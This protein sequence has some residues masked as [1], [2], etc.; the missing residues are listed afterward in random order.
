MVAV[1][2]NPTLY[3]ASFEALNARIAGEPTWLGERRRAAM[4]RFSEAGFPTPHDEDW[5]YTNLAGISSG[6]F[7][8]AESAS[9]TVA[10]GDIRSVGFEAVDAHRVVFVNGKL[11]PELSRLDDRG[12]G[13]GSLIDKRDDPVVAAHLSRQADAL[14]NSLAALNTAFFEDGI[15]VHV[16]E[17]VVEKKPVHLVWVTTG[18]QAE[19][20]THPRTLIVAGRDSQATVIETFV[21]IGEDYWTNA[22]TEV[23][24]AENAHIEHYKLQQEHISA[25]HT[26]F[27]FA[28][29][30]RDSNFAS[31]SLSFG[32]RMVRGDAHVRLGGEGCECTLNG[33]YTVTGDQ[34]VDHHTIIDHAEPHCNSHQLYRGV[35]DGRST[36][37]FNGKIIVR[38]DA[39]KT[40]AVQSNKNL[41]LSREADVNT[42]PQLEIEANDVRCTHGAT[43]GQLDA[44]AMFYLRSRGIGRADARSLLTYAFAADILEGLHVDGWREPLETLLLDWV[45][46]AETDQ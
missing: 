36:G 30:A 25:H 15:F 22:V 44:E 9:A 35:L 14:G 39:Q 13:I 11:A 7:V 23:V 26:G 20:S 24:A 40:D 19:H 46:Q 43:V 41:L 5:K 8:P 31:H 34:H 4:A 27:L 12:L 32:G 42:K 29:Q 45:K 37:V 17:R 2:E 33:L 28:D 38:P 18:E 21:G 3:R 10:A 6:R 1:A 16:P